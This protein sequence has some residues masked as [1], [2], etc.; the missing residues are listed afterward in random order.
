MSLTDWLCEK[1][2]LDTFEKLVKINNIENWPMPWGGIH[3]Q[4]MLSTTRVTTIKSEVKDSHLGRG[5]AFDGGQVALVEDFCGLHPSSYLWQEFM[6][7]WSFHKMWLCLDF[8]IWWERIPKYLCIRNLTQTK[9]RIYLY[10]KSQKKQYPNKYSDNFFPRIFAPIYHTL[11]S[12]V[13][14][15][16]VS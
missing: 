7:G 10:Q 14:I 5:W 2:S 16:G 1:H 12:K 4:W 9:N 13:M 15:S 3:C 6:V 11:T 8:R